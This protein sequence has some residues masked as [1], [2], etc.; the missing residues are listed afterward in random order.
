M[1]KQQNSKEALVAIIIFCRIHEREIR[2]F[3]T[4]YFAPD[5]LTKKGI[6]FTDMLVSKWS[7]ILN[8]VSVDS[9][10]VSE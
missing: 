8:Q 6:I 9:I 10:V 7:S 4:I 3:T 2:F 1:S 5:K